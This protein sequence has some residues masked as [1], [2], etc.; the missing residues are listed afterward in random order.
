MENGGGGVK[1]RR[2]RKGDNVGL[3]GQRGCLDVT[4]RASEERGK[5]EF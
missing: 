1:V 3:G 2:R 4:V 5:G